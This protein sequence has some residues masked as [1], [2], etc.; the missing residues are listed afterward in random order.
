V[1]RTRDGASWAMLDVDDTWSMEHGKGVNK[2]KATTACCS[3]YFYIA[4]ATTTTA[5]LPNC[6]LYYVLR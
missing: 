1:E 2:L 4:I 5:T 6:M 3:L